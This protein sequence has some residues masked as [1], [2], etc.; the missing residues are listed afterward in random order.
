MTTERFAAGATLTKARREVLMGSMAVAII[1][2]LQKAATLLT[3]GWGEAYTMQFR[4]SLW[5]GDPGM[6]ESLLR[7]LQGLDEDEDDDEDY[8][9]FVDEDEEV[10]EDYGEEDEEQSEDEDDFDDDEDE[11]MD[12]DEEI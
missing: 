8:D 10:E 4:N 5:S 6:P 9:D 3:E 12:E 2:H 11:L 1:R 7:L